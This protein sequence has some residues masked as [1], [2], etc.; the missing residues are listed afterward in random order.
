MFVRL[1]RHTIVQY[2]PFSLSL[3]SV[4]LFPK[5]L[6]LLVPPMIGNNQR[7]LSPEMSFPLD[8]F[9]YRLTVFGYVRSPGVSFV[10]S[11]LVIHF[12]G[13]FV[14]QWACAQ[15]VIAQCQFVGSVHVY[16]SAKRLLR[17]TIR[18]KMIH[19]R[20]ITNHR[21]CNKVGMFISLKVE[22]Q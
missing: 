14:L 3:C 9:V 16:F 18:L 5:L 4:D 20:S 1:L 10:W 22:L 11:F 19:T 17:C 7:G 2:A 21:H 13:A 6:L 12:T 8:P 15:E